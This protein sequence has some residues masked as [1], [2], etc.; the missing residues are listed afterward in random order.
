MLNPIHD[1]EL[2]KYITGIV[3]SPERKCKMLAINNVEDHVHMLVGL[4]PAYPLAK[5][6]QEVKANSSKLINEKGWYET[7]FQW[8]IGYGCFSY[9]YSEIKNVINYIKNQKEHHKE[10]AFEKEFLRLL[11]MF[12]MEYDLKYVF[13]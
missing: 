10:V 5:L 4:H 1:D 12:E 6:I 13:D 3:Q 7:K 9:A 8:Q 2:Q 11:D